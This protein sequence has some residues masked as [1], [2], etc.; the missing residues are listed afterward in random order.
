MKMKIKIKSWEEIEATLNKR[1]CKGYSDMMRGKNEIYFSRHNMGIHCG[2]V[3]EGYFSNWSR[4]IRAEEWYWHPD[5]YDIIFEG[6]DLEIIAE[7]DEMLDLIL[8]NR[9]R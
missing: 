7:L 4:N 9:E 1:H 3:I 2:A 6:D 8:R 5:W